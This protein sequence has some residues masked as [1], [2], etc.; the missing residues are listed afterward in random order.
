MFANRLSNTFEIVDVST[1]VPDMNDTPTIT[2]IA[3]RTKRRKLARRPLR[4]TFHIALLAELAHAV[5]HRF[6]RRSV[7]LTDNAT[8]GEE[9]HAIRV[10]RGLRIVGDHHDRLVE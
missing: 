7:Q 4:V 8:V 9:Y 3:V 5:E 2:A 1:S 10:R 6:G